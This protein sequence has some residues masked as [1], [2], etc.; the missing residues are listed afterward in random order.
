MEKFSRFRDSGTGIQVFLTPVAPSSAASASPLAILARLPAYLV[1]AVRLILLSIVALLWS[2]L[3]FIPATSPILYSIFGQASLLLIGFAPIATDKV[4]LKSRG[5]AAATSASLQHKPWQPKAGD[6]IL[7]NSSSWIDILIF[8]IKFNPQFTLPV[9]SEPPST[10][11]T[12]ATGTPNSKTARRRNA[13]ASVVSEVN[14]AASAAAGASAGGVNDQRKVLGFVPVPFLTALNHAASGQAPLY[15]SN[16]LAS[17]PLDIPSL[18]SR[19]QRPILIFPELVTSNNRGLLSA[20]SPAIFPQSWRDLY[21]ATGALRM[22]KGQAN[23]YIASVKYDP[24]TPFARTSATSSA[25]QP[26][27]GPLR[28]VVSLC[29][30]LTFAR[31]VQ[32]RLL[33]VDESPTSPGY[34]ADISALGNAPRGPEIDV[35]ADGVMGLIS[36]MSR[37]RKTGLGW[38]DKEAFL[39]V[40]KKG[41]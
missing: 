34:Q 6:V 19:S 7:C 3:S 25:P 4:S 2:L 28:H 32:L 37:L 14:A 24:P 9:V 36:S 20:L 15:P 10:A 39:A 22:G 26:A 21:R 13:G 17:Q 12:T 11:S 16:P 18:S 30:D 8:A 29:A 41:P 23:L 40:V 38:R 1:A 5:R 27:G 31:G 35:L 33:D